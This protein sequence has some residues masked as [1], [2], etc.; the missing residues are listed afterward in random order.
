MKATPN[1]QIKTVKHKIISA[2]H[3]GLLRQFC[4][5][6]FVIVY[7][8]YIFRNLELSFSNI[9]TLVINTVQVVATIIGFWLVM[10][11]KRS[12][13]IIFSTIFGA[14]LS[15]IIA[16]GDAIRSAHLCLV[17]MIVFMIPTASCLQSV[18]WFYP[19]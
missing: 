13:L 15:F 10:G 18:T 9:A 7:S 5:A 12:R 6:P 16:V 11:I 17:A 4:G 19:F 3:C 14:I 2:L 1:L 8:V